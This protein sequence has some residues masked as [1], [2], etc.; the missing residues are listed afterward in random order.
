MSIAS[1]AVNKPTVTSFTTFTLLVAGA[2]SYFNLGQLEDPEFTVKSATIV[3][4]YPGASAAEVELEVTDRIEI[5]IQELAQLKYVK[6]LS[7]PGSSIVQIEI[8]PS[9]DSK[10]LP[11]IWNQLRNKVDDVRGQLPPGAGT[12]QVVDDFGDVYGFLLAVTR[13]N[14]FTDAELESHVDLLKKELSLVPGVARVELWG[15]QPQCIYIDVQDSQLSQV[16][17]TMEQVHATLASQNAVVD[18][19]ALNLPH[20]RLR[21][22]QTGAFRSPEEI[23]D[24]TVAGTVNLT[25]GL[26]ATDEIIRIGDIGEVRRG[27][28]DPAA[29]M[30]RYNGQPAIGIAIANIP[31]ANIVDLGRA[32]D[33]RLHELEEQLPVGIEPHRISWQSDLVSESIDD[34]MISL[35][36]AVIIVL[37]VLWIAM[38][39]STAMVVGLCGLVFVILGSFL[40]MA[41]WGI[42]L[43]RMSLGALIIAMG[44]MVD[45]AIVVADGILV[46]IQQ[47]M[48]RKK[49]AIEA[50]TLPS[51]PLLG[52]TAIA[53]MAFYPIYASDES[54]GEYCASLFQVVAVALLLSWLLSVTITPLMCMWMLPQ[55]KTDTS[56]DRDPY[57]G[58]FYQAFGRL[59]RTAMQFRWL[60]VGGMAALLC[61][62]LFF[63][64]SIDRTFFPD[65]ARLQIMVDYWAPQGTRIE[66]VAAD[67]ERIE[68]QL[69]GDERVTAVSSFIGQGPPRFYLPVEPEKQYSCYA[70]LIVNV[71]DL[72][73]L[74]Q[75][76]PELDQ[77][78]EAN[79]PEAQTIVRRYG[80]GPCKTWTVEARLSGPA[81]ADINELRGLADQV[82]SVFDKSPYTEVVQTDWRQFEKKVVVNYDQERARWARVSR[83]N[84]GRATKRAF[85]GLPVG[86]YREGDKL[87]PILVRNTPDES[88][89]FIG[90]LGTLQVHPTN[91]TDTVP[92]AQPVSKIDVEW[93]EGII[94][95]RDRRRTITIQARTADGVPASLL[96]GDIAAAVEAIELPPGYNLEWGGEYESARD[97]QK[98]LIPGVVPAVVIVA[99]VL[100][101]LFDGFRPPLIILCTIPFAMIGVVVGLLSTGQPFGFLALLGAMSLA[102]MMIKN[103][104]VLLD[105][106]NIEK[107]EGKSD[108]HAVLAAAKS[109]LRPVLLAAGTTVLGV[110]PLLQD[111]FWVAMAVTIMFG[112]AFGTVLTMVLLPVLYAC[113]FQVEVPAEEK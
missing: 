28:K 16:G 62:A 34:F 1:V 55:P 98:S 93:D 102:G 11:A 8:K 67:L 69:L 48:D 21:I 33:Q 88:R 94:W 66:T 29:N 76:V 89:Q 50:A 36:E 106:I 56:A 45:N 59:L 24:L 4:S 109:R 31:G 40:V 74:N 5:A 41:L 105:Q 20:E 17:I 83:E 6:S 96:Q 92:L 84:V 9:Y 108:Y 85:D 77:W 19:G 12:P 100:V 54:A 87:L 63:F 107:A 44:M 43:Q 79:V 73:A 3:T 46:R 13:D 2:L 82:V 112:L 53:G 32:I 111:V 27:Y 49:A 81:V 103:A 97:S 64:G 57:D 37:V 78:A 39:F 68:Q 65:S 51:L 113:F 91:S 72:Q 26:K 90:A 25:Q 86:Q 75:L 47:G 110:I 35:A 99:L 14:A 60:V 38:G 18:S 71:R 58:K 23:A 7:R 70:Q 80:L 10:E 101:G 61:V 104:I 95:R 52:A 42:D 22:E 30:M 15:V